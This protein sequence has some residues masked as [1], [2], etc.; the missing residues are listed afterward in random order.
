MWGI[1]HLYKNLIHYTTGNNNNY[2]NNN[3]NNNKKKKIIITNSIVKL[4]HFRNIFRALLQ[5]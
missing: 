5:Q 2:N 4:G 3:N 1:R